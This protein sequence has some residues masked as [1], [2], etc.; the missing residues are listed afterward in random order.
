[1]VCRLPIRRRNIGEG[2]LPE[3]LFAYQ[4]LR[5]ENRRVLLNTS[6]RTVSHCDLNVFVP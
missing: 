3:R 6:R 5:E 1:M 2:S 4:A